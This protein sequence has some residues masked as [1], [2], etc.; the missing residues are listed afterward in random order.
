MFSKQYLALLII[1]GVVLTYFHCDAF[2]LRDED[3]DDSAADVTEESDSDEDL[4]GKRK[5][6]F[7]YLFLCSNEILFLDEKRAI[8]SFLE[9]QQDANQYLDQARR[10]FSDQKSH[11]KE[12]KKKFVEKIFHFK[13]NQN[14]FFSFEDTKKSVNDSCIHDIVQIW[15]L[16]LHGI[17]HSHK[18]RAKNKLKMK[19]LVFSSAWKLIKFILDSTWNFIFFLLSCHKNN[20]IYKDS[21]NLKF[22]CLLNIVWVELQE[23][24]KKNLNS[25]QIFPKINRNPIEQLVY[26]RWK[27][28]KVE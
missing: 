11:M 5:L 10:L 13:K 22:L 9:D 7:N 12:A 4:S 25:K 3:D 26:K 23:T 15:T 16:G 21:I 18:L 14:L 17:R 24:D 8:E 6:D 2:T 19:H 20:T 28:I 1:F 27:I